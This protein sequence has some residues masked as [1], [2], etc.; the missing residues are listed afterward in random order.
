[1]ITEFTAKNFKS[2]QE[3]TLPL[4]RINVLIGENGS[5]KSNILEAIGLLAA[6]VENKLDNE[7]LFARGIRVTSPP[8]MRAGFATQSEAQNIEFTTTDEFGKIFKYQ[9]SNQNHLYSKWE[10]TN[11]NYQLDE[12]ARNTLVQTLKSFTI[13]QFK[14]M[15][16]N[17]EQKNLANQTEDDSLAALLSKFFSYDP[18]LKLYLN[19]S[20]FSLENS[21]LRIYEKEGQLEPLG[22]NGEG[23]FKLIKYFA[24]EP[25]AV[26]FKELRQH[27]Q[28][29]DW[30]ED[31]EIPES[32]LEAENYLQ[33]RD[34]YLAEGIRHFDQRSVNEGFLFVLFY[35]CLLISDLTPKFFAIDN[36]EASLNPKLCTKLMK[37][38]VEL[39]KKSDKQLVIT[40]HSPAVLDGLD[41]NDDEQRLFLVY[42]NAHGHTKVKRLEKPQP[43][44][45]Q[46]PVKLSEAFAR[47]YLGG[48]PK[49]F[50][51]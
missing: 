14:S 13:E 17:L 51:L 5:G 33:I 39:A 1:M 28:L 40:T 19:F 21:A 44:S 18:S 38:M 24:T 48:L 42:R 3:L 11:L 7:V 23:L 30:F 45:G 37:S 27:L 4:G 41:L 15:S 20:I 50:A 2:I 12:N 25:G 32:F 46:D 26:K 34:R 16:K 47:G 29:F 35:F 31:I 36:I 8:L 43:L 22:I 6:A 9:L 49:N 10:V